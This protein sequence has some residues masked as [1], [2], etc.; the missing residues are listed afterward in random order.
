MMALNKPILTA[1][2]LLSA[3]AVP[4]QG[5]PPTA[6]RYRTI[7]GT[8]N[9]RAEHRQRWGAAHTALIRYTGEGFADGTAAPAG[10]DRPNPRAISNALF[11]QDDLLND[12]V[13]LS[14]FTWVFGQFIDHDIGLT[15]QPGEPLMIPV[16]TG[17]PIF[18]PFR[19]G[20]VVIP[21][22]RNG[23]RLGTGFGTGNP[24]QY[25]NEITAYIDGSAVYGSDEL[26][27]AWLRT[28][29]DGKLKVS[30]GGLLPYDT[31]NGEID[32]RHDAAAPHMANAVNFRGALFVAGDPR[33]NENPVLAALHTLFVREH[34]RRCD[35]LRADHPDWSDEQLYQHARK[36]VGGAIQRIV[37]EEWLPA[38]GVP[39]GDYAGYDPG[40]NP[41]LANVFTAAAFRV[42]H[43][44]LNSTLRRTD[45][46]GNVLPQGNI[47]LRDAFFN[48]GAI[49]AVGGIEPYLRGMAEQVQQRMDNHVVDDVRNFLF[50]PPGAGGLDLAAINIM[51]GRERGLPRYNKVRQAYRLPHYVDFRELN[52]DPAVHA[53]LAEVYGNDINKLDP[54]V[55]MLAEHPVEGSIFGP[56]LRTILNDQFRKLRTGDRFYYLND[57]VL[58]EAEKQE[59]HTTTFRDIIMYNTDIELMQED[60]FRSM[61]FSQICGEAAISVDGVIRIHGS[62]RPL[63]GVT[64]RAMGNDGSPSSSRTTSELGFYDFRALPACR[65]TSIE[66]TRDDDW[67]RGVNV[68]DIVALR[69]HILGLVEFDTPYARLAADVNLDGEL[70]V[71]DLLGIQRVILGIDE[72]FDPERPTPWLFIPAAYA[73]PDPARPHT[74]DYPVRINFDEVPATAVNQGFVAVKYG[75][76]NGDY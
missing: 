5:A 45:A 57:P 47:S 14:D 76:V 13:G 66:A 25:D 49:P 26:R 34:N 67:E 36:F 33:A 10:P 16:P 12:P 27:A 8:Y 62:D 39:V 28:F 69:R 17:D 51:R 15:E 44:L 56:T 40:V 41:Q 52:P 30:A 19:T 4:A 24:R 50:G 21:M 65:T 42:G 71:F 75:D 18:D 7:N 32:G 37:Y 2:L 35:L 74:A 31:R 72:R 55:G 43:T 11:A 68:F 61:P 73:F 53:A 64:V 59:I 6:E 22:Q 63:G 3:A 48:P 58:T 1:A 70:D 29:A 54:W 9:N 20:R 23:H 38:M 46:A 60:V